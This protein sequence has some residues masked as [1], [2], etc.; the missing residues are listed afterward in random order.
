MIIAGTVYNS[1]FFTNFTVLV[2]WDF[3]AIIHFIIMTYKV[4]YLIDINIT[5]STK[6]FINCICYCC[7][8]KYIINQKNTLSPRRWS[9]LDSLSRKLSSRQGIRHLTLQD[10]LLDNNGFEI[11]MNHLTKEFSTVSIQTN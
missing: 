8:Q 9:Q 10:V 6:D 7:R 3:V 4:L 11:F 2:F 5:H 1:T